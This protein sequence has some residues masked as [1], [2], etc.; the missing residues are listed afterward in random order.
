[1]IKLSENN[2]LPKSMIDV[3]KHK[4]LYRPFKLDC[5]VCK[6]P[7]KILLELFAPTPKQNLQLVK[8]VYFVLLKDN[9]TWV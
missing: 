6:S 5:N 4:M 3:P 8:C 9:P 2:T 7:D 1:M